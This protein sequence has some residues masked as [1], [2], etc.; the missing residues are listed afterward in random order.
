M[1]KQLKARLYFLVA[2]YFRFWAALKLH[3]WHPRVIVITGS[4]GKTTLLHLLEAQLGSEAHYSHHANSSFGIPFDILGLHGID[5]SRLRW[6]GLFLMAPLAA[7]TKPYTEKLY[8]AEVDADRP[9]EGAFLA[10]LLKPEVT[11]WVSALHSHTAQ[12][13]SAVQAGRFETVREAV[14]H[15]YGNV[16]AATRKLVILDGDNDLMLSQLDRTQADTQQV[17]IADLKSYTLNP[18]TSEFVFQGVTYTIPAILPRNN[19]YQLAMVDGLLRYLNK[20]PDYA[21]KNFVMPPGR[22]NIFEGIKGTTIFDSTYNNSNIDSL[23]SVLE[24]FEAYPAEHKWAVVGDMLEQGQDEAMEHNK[25]AE[26]LASLN[27]ERLILI[28]PRVA[29]HTAPRLEGKLAANTKLEVFTQPADVLIYLQSNLHGGET[30]L[31]K[32][33]RY[34]EGV[35]EPLLANPSDASKLARRGAA[36]DKKRAAWGVGPS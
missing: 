32:G 23:R 16:A 10:K 13:D 15:E 36:W 29:K 28:G 25:L 5:G 4:A 6:F 30:I 31:F 14:A 24:T 7:F 11:L 17:K 21:Y 20:T 18:K 2:R 9:H 26:A 3:R 1:F 19:Y 22:S 8:V 34:L 12:Y 35:I 27:V 33:I